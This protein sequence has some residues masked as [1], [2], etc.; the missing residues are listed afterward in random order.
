MNGPEPSEPETSGPEPAPARRLADVLDTVNRSVSQLLAAPSG[1]PERVRIEA[2]EVVVEVEW[3]RATA[4][5][6]DPLPG[7]APRQQAPPSP[8]RV[9]TAEAGSWYVC[10]PSVG[11]FYRSP[12]PGQDPFVR[13]QDV[14]RSG[15]QVAIV[16]VMKLM[17][18]VEAEAHGRIIE[19]LAADGAAVEYGDRLF[20]VAPVDAS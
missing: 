17:L 15:Q 19:V 12:E 6:P 3:P 13:E 10:A 16:E 9:D 14:V 5:A 4:S 7:G 2:G 18:P 11:T 1:R 8:A 20:A